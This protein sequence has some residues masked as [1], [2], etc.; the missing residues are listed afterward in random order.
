M[1]ALTFYFFNFF[2]LIWRKF[3]TPN[4]NLH[5]PTKKRFLQKLTVSNTRSIKFVSFAQ[6]CRK[7]NAYTDMFMMY[8]N[9]SVHGN[10]QELTNE[11]VFCNC[12]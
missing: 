10:I 1:K 6:F 4:V 12:Y 8:I 3:A 5:L 9:L 2:F 7:I 11:T